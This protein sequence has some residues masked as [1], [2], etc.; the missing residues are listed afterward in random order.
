MFAWMDARA[1]LMAGMVRRLGIDLPTVCT[2]GG[3]ERYGM[4]ARTCMM[5]SSARECRAWLDGAGGRDRY[6]DFCPNARSFD[7][8][9]ECVNAG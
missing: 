5:C 1:D 9:R 3:A 7:T 2:G 8:L 4:M 6:R